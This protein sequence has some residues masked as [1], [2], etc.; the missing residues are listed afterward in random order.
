MKFINISLLSLILV[1]TSGCGTDKD[2]SNYAATAAAS[3]SVISKPFSAPDTALM[4]MDG[5]KRKL[6]DYRGKP[7]IVNFWATWCPPCRA[8][9]PS[10]NRAWSKV[11]D[12]GIIMLAVNMGESEETIFPFT[13]DYPIDFTILLDEDGAFALDWKVK[14]LPTTYVVN[15]DGQ[16]VYQAVGGREW[17]DKKIL[18]VVRELKK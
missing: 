18:D 9:L 10:M 5:V 14:G 3:I 15:P 16:V 6:S 1:I 2:K 17:D 8:E 12:E 13:G 4:D 7:V 11:K